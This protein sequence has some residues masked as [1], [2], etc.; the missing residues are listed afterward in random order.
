MASK[1]ISHRPLLVASEG[2]EGVGKCANT[3][4]LR[5]E[6]MAVLAQYAGLVLWDVYHIGRRAIGNHSIAPECPANMRTFGQFPAA[7]FP[8]SGG[9]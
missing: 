5:Q 4:R 3:S 1:F 7:I 2:D 6:L 9:A 8:V